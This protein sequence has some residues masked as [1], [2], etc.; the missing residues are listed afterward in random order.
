MP[1]HQHGLE[2][3]PVANV[4]RRSLRVQAELEI[5]RRR[6]R[7]ARPIPARAG[8][9][10]LLLH[11]CGSIMGHRCAC[12]ENGFCGLLI[13]L[14]NGPSLRVQG[15]RDGYVHRYPGA[16]AIPARAGRTTL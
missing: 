5:Y 14:Q 13:M 6:E 7:M 4:H 1:I 16:R 10:R 3:D 15:E 8:R 11:G 9:T 2:K 12:R